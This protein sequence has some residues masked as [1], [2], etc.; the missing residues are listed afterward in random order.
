MQK[1]Y[2]YLWY[3]VLIYKLSVIVTFEFVVGEIILT[4]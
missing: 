4:S 3:Q 2:M 1:K